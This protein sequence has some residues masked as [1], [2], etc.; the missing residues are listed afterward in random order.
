MKKTFIFFI[1][2]V[3]LA[4]CDFHHPTYM[5]ENKIRVERGVQR[6]DMDVH[7]FSNTQA[8]IIA[9]DYDGAGAGDARLSVTYDPTSPIN[10]AAHAR[11]HLAKALTL[12]RGNG[13]STVMGNIMPV[14]NSGEN[15][16][17]LLTY[18]AYSAHAPAGCGAMS[19]LNNNVVENDRDYKLG[20]SRDTLFAR[21]IARPKDLI[22]QGSIGATTDGR[23]A[24]NILEPYRA[25]IPNESLRGESA[26][27][28][29]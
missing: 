25:G 19:G 1:C 20:C 9:H 2:I 5:T 12:L 26:S 4:A 21:Q 7:D 27:G 24:A 29:N 14:H 15:S 23:R 28:S 3:G 11:T 10:T 13:L 16:R 22:G 6:H 18:D 8:K 17:L